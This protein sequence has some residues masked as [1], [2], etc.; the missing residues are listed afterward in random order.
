LKTFE[1][2]DFVVVGHVC[3][4]I[5]PDGSLGLGGSVSYAATTAHRL[6]Y[7]V[8]VV[9]RTGPDLDV[10]KALPGIE[11]V[12]HRSAATTMFENIYFDGRRRQILHQRADVITC[13][14]IPPP[15]RRAPLAYLGSIDQ[16][17][18]SSVFGCFSDEAIICVMPQGFFRRWD[19][20][21]QVSF[22]EWTPPE[23]ILR[24]IN[25]LVI[26]ELDVPDPVA[27]AYDWGR[28]IP[29]IVVTQAERGATVY[30]AGEPCHYA[31]RLTQQVDPT[32]AGD[33]FAAAFLIRL[34]ETGDPR[35]AAPF[36]NSV[37]SFSVEGPGMTSIP[38]R[39]QVDAYLKAIGERSISPF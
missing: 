27:L 24:C 16:E 38:H 29:T 31:A 8:G 12:C 30:H 3:Q 9:T 25:V 11:I 36:A 5:L 22:A 15:W 18:D 20:Q 1:C 17:I 39:E 28:F 13:E 26:S 23:A 10:T 2:P 14:Q 4:D 21:G 34:A 19:E 6:G 32:G 7:R 35:L 37:A 33:V